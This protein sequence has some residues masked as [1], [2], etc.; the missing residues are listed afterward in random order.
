M[1]PLLQ[2]ISEQVT[3]YE[4]V[5][6]PVWH[7]LVFLYRLIVVIT[8]GGAVYGD[9]QSAFKCSQKIPGCENACYN[10][11]AQISHLRFWAFQILAITTPTVFFNLYSS[12]VSGEIRKLKSSEEQLRIVED[13][14]DGQLTLTNTLSE[15]EIGK[16]TR[17]KRGI[18]NLKVKLVYSDN[19]IKEVPVT[20][21]I[22]AA[23]YVSVLLR[24]VLEGGFIYLGYVLYNIPIYASCVGPNCNAR[25]TIA[26]VLWMKVPSE[27]RCIG[28]PGSEVY[29]ICNMHYGPNA[30]RGYVPCITSRATE[31]TVFLRYMTIL[32]VICFILSALELIYLTIKSIWKKSSNNSRSNLQK[33]IHPE[34]FYFPSPPQIATAPS[35]LYDEFNSSGLVVP[36]KNASKELRRSESKDGDRESCKS[37]RSYV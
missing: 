35:K 12:F 3:R 21:K 2:K 17:R 28:A 25:S 31:K 23:Y 10:S 33:S 24:L 13:K 34:Q 15:R 16:M 11:F 19:E 18:G 29:N 4:T 37:L 20:N 26:S 6:G 7:V 14:R 5:V 32:S 8:V 9:E 27:Y 1:W 36:G 30:E 22:K